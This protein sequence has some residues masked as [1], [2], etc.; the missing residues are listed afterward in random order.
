MRCLVRQASDI[1]GGP[2]LHSETRLRYEQRRTAGHLSID[3]ATRLLVRTVE[4]RSV[5]YIF[6]DALDECER[7]TR[8]ELTKALEKILN[9]SPCLIKIFVSS[10][11]DQDIVL[12]L[13][14]YPNI[15]I[16][17]RQNQHDIAFYISERTQTLINEKRL[18]GAHSVT[19]ELQ[20]N[21]RKRLSEGAQ[22]M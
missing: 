13:E 15:V 18:L 4:Q 7:T 20:E 10:R 21:I 1:P 14:N 16:D 9:D 11:D 8:H 19:G 17:A 3:E 6:L 5:T 12:S 2:E 22:G